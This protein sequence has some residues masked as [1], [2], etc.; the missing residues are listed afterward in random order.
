MKRPLQELANLAKEHKAP[1]IYAGDIFDDGWRVRGCPPQL[2]N[3]AIQNL[4]KG[5][6]IPGQHDLP[7]HRYEDIEKSAYWTLV[8]AEV[9]TNLDPEDPVKANRW[10]ALHAFP[11]GMDLRH[12][13]KQVKKDMEDF[14]GEPVVHL[15][16]CHKYIYNPRIKGSMHPGAKEEDDVYFVRKLLEGFT[17]A[18]FGDNHIAF[19]LPFPDKDQ[20]RPH[21]FNCGGFMRRRSDQRDYYP[22]VGLL[23]KDGT[24]TRHILK[25]I[26]DDV[27]L[28]EE[29]TSRLRQS[30]NGVSTEDIVELL[31]KLVE[32]GGDFYS[33]VRYFMRKNKIKPDV[34]AAVTEILDKTREGKN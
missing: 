6:A 13:D 3:F 30:V 31:S 24:V 10:L 14:D 20:I 26:I 11:W 8:E 2:I 1:I 21:V 28:S 23:H 17:T 4:P 9:L 32:A 22:S 5:Y 12:I 34:Q 16:V 19:E 27:L 33:S 7:H 18:V 15:A 25:N 29:D